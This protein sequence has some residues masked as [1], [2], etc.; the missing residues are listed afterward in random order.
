[1][2]QDAYQLSGHGGPDGLL[3]ELIIYRVKEYQA[4]RSR[5][6]TALEK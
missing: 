2:L 5:S 4:F 3:N 1:M 6:S